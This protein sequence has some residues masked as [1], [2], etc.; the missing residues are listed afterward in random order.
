MKPLAPISNSARVALGVLF[1]VLFVG[2]WSFATLGGYVSKTFLADPL[3]MVEEGYNLLVRHGFLLDI[4]ITIWRG[5][6]GFGL[7][8]L[9]RGPIGILRAAYKPIEAFL[10][11]FVSFAR[12]LP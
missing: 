5:R 1:F 3:T 9:V 12:Y 6:G 4:G 11:P 2:V 7:G 8:G 10:E